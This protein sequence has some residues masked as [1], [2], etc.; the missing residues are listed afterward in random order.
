VIT[1]NM[2]NVQEVAD[3]AVVLRLGQNNGVF[4]VATTTGEEMVAAITGAT[5]SVVTRRA[6]RRAAHEHEEQR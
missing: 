4:D 1:H 2:A 6:Q 5:D 3:R